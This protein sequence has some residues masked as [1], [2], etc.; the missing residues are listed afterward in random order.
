MRVVVALGVRA[1]DGHGYNYNLR[2]F[3]WQSTNKPF[4]MS[5]NNANLNGNVV[6][7]SLQNAKGCQRLYS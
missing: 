7:E 2:S 5:S 3:D 1:R 4:Q 6:D